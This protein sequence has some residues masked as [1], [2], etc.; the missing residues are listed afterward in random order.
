MTDAERK[1]YYAGR[2]AAFAE[3]LPDL[4]ALNTDGERD[5]YRRGYRHA[6]SEDRLDADAEWDA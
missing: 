5:E 4:C 3:E 2:A 1:A 6:K